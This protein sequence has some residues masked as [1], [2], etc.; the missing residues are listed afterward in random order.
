MKTFLLYLLSLLLTATTAF[1]QEKFNTITASLETVG[2]TAT[3]G[4]FM[5]ATNN[6]KSSIIFNSIRPLTVKYKGSP[7]FL[8]VVDLPD[9]KQVVHFTQEQLEAL[10]AIVAAKD[11]KTHYLEV[12]NFF[13][14]YAAKGKAEI[15]QQFLNNVHFA[16]SKK[17]WYRNNAVFMVKSMLVNDQH[18]IRFQLPFANNARICRHVK[19]I[20][21]L[22]EEYYEATP[23]NF[24]SLFVS[25]ASSGNIRVSAN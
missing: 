11:G 4:N 21:H 19:A 9:E 12:T 16:I 1:S 23:A 25:H 15:N 22:E 6:R 13:E 24:L 18:V 2:E 10:Q 8:M 14:V 20:H 7:W 3:A 5:A 17:H